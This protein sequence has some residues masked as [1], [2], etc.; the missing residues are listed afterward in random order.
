MS[1]FIYI[2]VYIHVYSVRTLY[3]LCKGVCT[4]TPCI[5]PSPDGTETVGGGSI[6]EN[7]SVTGDGV[8][9]DAVRREVGEE[10]RRSSGCQSGSQDGRDG[11]GERRRDDTS[12]DSLSSRE[13]GVYLV[14][15]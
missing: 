14:V 10:V 15:Y 11:E 13:A 4:C 8:P 9:G 5:V 3:I 6:L 2:H 1:L 12:R 7:D